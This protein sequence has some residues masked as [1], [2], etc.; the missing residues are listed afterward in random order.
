M[1]RYELNFSPNEINK[2]CMDEWG[3][4]FLWKGNKGCEFNLAYDDGECQ[5]AIYKCDTEGEYLD[6]DTSTFI[7]YEVD[8]YSD[9]WAKDLI[10]A[11]EKAYYQFWGRH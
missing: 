8:K 2:K 9:R 1:F 3:A 6:T 5:S 7:P 10:I 4:A 11:M